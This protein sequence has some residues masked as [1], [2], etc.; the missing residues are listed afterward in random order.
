MKI[1]KNNTSGFTLIETLVAL[2]ILLVSIA[3][4]LTIASKGLQ[5]SIYARDQITA[6]YLEQDAIEYIR[7]KRDGNTLSLAA[8]WLSGFG[9]NGVAPDC[10]RDIKC[11]VD[12]K[13]DTISECPAGG[14]LPLRYNESTGFYGYSGADSVSRFTREVQIVSVNPPDEVTIVVSIYWQTGV[15]VRSF[16]VKE[17]IFNWQ[18]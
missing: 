1:V 9:I 7:S 3:G 2:A 11:V 17:N 12:V 6:F 15:F 13:N 4:P 16:T 5:S 18:M 8:N 10:T 14:C